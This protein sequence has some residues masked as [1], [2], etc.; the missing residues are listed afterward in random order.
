MHLSRKQRQTQRVDPWLPRGSGEG[1]D[2]LKVWGEQM[3]TVCYTE[4]QQGPAV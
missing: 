3:Q 2:G 1:K 4:K